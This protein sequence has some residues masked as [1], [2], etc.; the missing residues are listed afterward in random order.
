MDRCCY[1]CRTKTYGRTSAHIY[2]LG[3]KILIVGAA[4]TCSDQTEINYKILSEL[5]G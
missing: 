5:N 2:W 1:F 4:G 3:H